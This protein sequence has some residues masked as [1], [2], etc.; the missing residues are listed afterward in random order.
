[1]TVIIEPMSEVRRRAALPF[2]QDSGLSY[3]KPIP[4][5]GYGQE[6]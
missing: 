3:L 6:L 1:M 5:K 2:A 4:K